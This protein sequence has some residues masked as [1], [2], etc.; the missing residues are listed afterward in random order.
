[1]VFAL[2]RRIRRIR[3]QSVGSLALRSRRAVDSDADAIQALLTK[4]GEALAR[5]GFLN[6]TP[7]Y[8]LERIRTYIAD[9]EVY[10]VEDAGA[11]VATYTLG[12][13]AVPPYSAPPWPQPD[14]P[15]LYLNRLAVDPERQR[16]GI[17]RWC[18]D[19]V[20]DRAR[21]AGA[22]AVRC[23]VL[24]SNAALRAFYERH[25]Y[26]RRGGRR[27]SGWQFTCYELLLTG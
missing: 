17:G 20:E 16:E 18:L 10:V 14:S 3:T 21:A 4:A 19:D 24:Q 1:M 22:A 7:A 12:L 11:L 15:A 8:T 26:I 25:G 27:H 9:R 13:T 2:S 6:W 23:D 5:Q